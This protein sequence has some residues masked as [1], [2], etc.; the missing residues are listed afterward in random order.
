MFIGIYSHFGKS[1]LNPKINCNSK[2]EKN[3]SSVYLSLLCLCRFQSPFFHPLSLLQHFLPSVPPPP[4]FLPLRTPE[5]CRP[6]LMC[7]ETMRQQKLL[8]CLLQSFELSLSQF[9]QNFQ[10]CFWKLWLLL[11][12]TWLL[13]KKR[14]K[15]TMSSPEPEEKIKGVSIVSF[16][17]SSSLR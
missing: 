15:F 11:F 6:P 9:L 8:L 10:S 7:S 2:I 14:R 1:K 13:Q 17:P 4:V 16:L 5:V 12:L 3:N